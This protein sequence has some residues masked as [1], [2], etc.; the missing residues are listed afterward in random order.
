MDRNIVSELSDRTGLSLV[1]E[2]RL[3]RRALDERGDLKQGDVARAA[4][5]KDTYVSHRLRLLDLPDSLLSLVESGKLTHGAA[6][7]LF[8]LLG[9]VCDHADV[10][11]EIGGVLRSANSRGERLTARVV[12][13]AM[14][15]VCTSL[16]ARFL[17]L[18]EAARAADGAA[19]AH[20][21]NFDVAEFAR[22]FADSIH[23][24]PTLRESV[25]RVKFSC[26]VDEW[27]LWRER[28]D[29]GREFVVIERN[30]KRAIA[31]DELANLASGGDRGRLLSEAEQNGL[32]FLRPL[33]GEGSPPALFDR[34]FC[35]L[36]CVDGAI[37]PRSKLGAPALHC[38]NRRCFDGRL[39]RF[40]REFA[41]IEAERR[42]EEDMERSALA[43]RYARDLDDELLMGLGAA[44]IRAGAIDARAT[45]PEEARCDGTLYEVADL[46]YFS[47][48]A[49][50]VAETLGLERPA[51]GDPDAVAWREEELD[52]LVGRMGWRDAVCD[53]LAL[54]ARPPGGGS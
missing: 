47:Q 30:W 40:K 5:V 1:E 54:V 18:F 21:P 4:G 46:A 26:A 12:R 24:L 17:P 16:P 52:D 44:I 49:R 36:S 33:F 45:L 25:G 8:P 42:L 41:A 32:E 13:R 3:F 11:E 34:D 48:A 29:D 39:E 6:R 22:R 53:L 37:Y 50:R 9:R 2:A 38:S 28:F 14:A 23:A 10:L 35:V 20:A 7:E 31:G 27:G 19:C 15:E 51:D 43:A